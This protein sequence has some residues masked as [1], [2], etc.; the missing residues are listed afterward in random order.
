MGANHESEAKLQLFLQWLQ[1]NGVEL[2]CC[3]I[4]SCGPNKGFGVFTSCAPSEDGNASML[5][6]LTIIMRCIRFLM[7]L[8]DFVGV[9]W[10]FLSISLSLLCASSKILTQVLD[11]GQCS[12][13]VTYLDMLPTTFGNPLWFT[14]DELAELKGTTLYRASV[15]QR[16]NL[17]ALYDDK[18]KV[19]VDELLRANAHC[20]RAY[21]IFWTRALNI[22]F[23]RSYV[24]PESFGDQ[25]NNPACHT[26]HCGAFKAEMAGETIDDRSGGTCRDNSILFGKENSADTSSSKAGETVW[27]EGLVPGIDFCNHGLK[28]AAT[29]D[30]DQMGSM[31]GIPSSMY[32]LLADPVSME[33]DKE[34]CISYG[35]KGNEELL[36]LYGFIIDINPSD[37]LMVHYPLELL[38]NAP[39]SESKEKLLELQKAELRCL[40]PRSL[41]DN[42][43]YTDCHKDEVSERSSFSWSGQRKVPSYLHKLVFPQEFMAALRTIT[44]QDHEIKKATSLLA[45]LVG[46]IDEG[47]A[48]EADVR[49]AVWESCGDYAALELLVDLFRA[50]KVEVLEGELGQLKT[51]FEEKILDFQNQFSSIHEKMDGRFAALEDLMKKMIDDKQKPASSETIGGHGRGGNPNPLWGRENSEV[52]VL[53]GDDGMP[54]LE[55]L[56]REELSRGYDR[57]EADYVGRREEFYRRG[58][59][60]ERIQRRGADFEGEGIDFHRRGAD[61]ERSQRRGADFE[62]RREEMHRRGADFERIQRRGDEFEG[63]RGEMMELEESSGNV[64]NDSKLLEDFHN[65]ELEEHM[66][67]NSSTERKGMTRNIISCIVYRRGQK[68]LTSLF[69]KEAEQALELCANE[70]E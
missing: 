10:L 59:G 48:S 19:L 42:G 22:P 39:L 50:K 43:F 23:P 8:S 64:E 4:K 45:E 35:N 57:R 52:E 56:S 58:A 66:R 6:A 69:L 68:Q 12:R 51:D 16:K 67:E 9:A 30:V 61:I 63:R 27:V 26:G 37:Y 29:W 11:A 28:P 70:Q 18:V 38:Q 3:T 53:E 44:M 49:A 34:I 1:V 47:Q 14:E 65:L 41:L 62:G 36:Y 40:L 17:Q 55:P 21:S 20:N 2:R 25:S 54:P 15:L 46:S 13:R 24:F 5:P 60:F 31:T 33:I 32:L 7:P